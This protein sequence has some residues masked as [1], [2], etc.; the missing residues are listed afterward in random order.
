MS[1]N[2][3]NNPTRATRKSKTSNGAKYDRR[4]RQPY[5]GVCFKAGKDKSVYTSHWTRENANPD[6]PVVCPL[7]LSTVCGY[8]K[9]TGHSIKYCQKRIR[10]NNRLQDL[11]PPTNNFL[12]NSSSRNSL[13]SFDSLGSD[14]YHSESRRQPRKHNRN[15]TNSPSPHVLQDKPI[16]LPS[17]PPSKWVN[18]TQGIPPNIPFP[19]LQLD[20]TR[21]ATFDSNGRRIL[22]EWIPPHTTSLE[23]DSFA[24]IMPL[25]PAPYDVPY[26]IINE[27]RRKR[28]H[29]WA[30]CSDDDSDD[31]RNYTP[32]SMRDLDDVSPYRIPT[33][34]SESSDNDNDFDPEYDHYLIEL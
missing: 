27:Y 12:S 30:D 10:K 3:T 29:N 6:S 5:C 16:Q 1:Q 28:I 23:N 4:K 9:D 18:A 2:N 7:I 17:P 19:N 31:E 24:P 33:S 14:N 21:I 25:P 34:S 11:P 22:D 26:N 20:T 8:C 15:Y 13:S 32:I